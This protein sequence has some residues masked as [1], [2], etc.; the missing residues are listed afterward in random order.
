MNRP[1]RFWP[2][3]VLL[4]LPLIPLFRCLFLGQTIGAWDEIRTMAPWNRASNGRPWDVLQ[5]DSVLEFY[6]WRDQVFKAWGTYHI[7]LWNH[8]ELG[9]TPLLAN[10][11][12]GALYPPHIVV[13]LLHVPTGPAMALLAWL[14]LA[15]AGIGVYLLSRRFGGSKIGALL[16]GAAFSMSPFMIG[17]AALPSVT[18]TV[19]WIPWGILAIQMLPRRWGVVLLALSV[20]MMVSAGHLQFAA[21]GGIAWLIALVVRAFAESNARGQ[22]LVRA[23]VGLLLGAFL[24]APHIWPVLAYA[25]HS[26]RKTAPTME[27]YEAYRSGALPAWELLSIPDSTWLGIPTKPLTLGGA[28]VGGFWPA[29]VQRGGNFAESAIGIGPVALILLVL[30]LNRERLRNGLA[31]VLVAIT[32]LAL[33]IGLPLGMLLYFGIPGW[34]ATGSPGRAGVLFVLGACVLAGSCL[35][36][37]DLSNLRPWRAFCIFGVLAVVLPVL[38]L[39][40]IHPSLWVS[41]FDFHDLFPLSNAP[42]AI[43]GA[44]AACLFVSLL[45]PSGPLR[46]AGIVGLCLVVGFL[47]ASFLIRSSDSR[48]VS[49]PAV[50]DQ[51][52]IA[53]VNGPWSLLASAA[54]LLP[55]NTAA[56][57]SINEIGGYDSLIDVRTRDRLADIDGEDPAPAANGNM[58]FVKSHFDPAKLADAGVTEVWSLHPLPQMRTEPREA[59]GFLRYPLPGLGRAYTESGP[60]TIVHETASW[61]DVEASG[62]GTLVLKDNLREGWRLTV[63]DL[64]AR[65]ETIPWPHAA[66]TR[67]RHTVHFEYWPDGLT[68]GFTVFVFGVLGLVVIVLRPP[69][70]D[71]VEAGVPEGGS[72]GESRESEEGGQPSDEP[73]DRSP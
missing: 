12:T 34:A 58:M 1:H 70:R 54:A 59:S 64:P 56:L 35:K 31:P 4:A 16:G 53:V 15:W 40:V 26:H 22:F 38:A 10:S 7:P 61:I 51:T 37:E 50:P 57:S 73:G 48:D 67:G 25:Q 29:L 17:W 2:A 47:P 66:L 72:A 19:A 33:A 21:Y 30:G 44:A 32:G 24:A 27:G 9:G 41:G 71:G 52:R 28:T 49:V 42:L 68:Q 65:L 45:R 69:R 39:L 55:P 46:A 60:A 63:D 3:L 36:A 5:A 11:Q 20:A 43:G 18:E 14:H 62:P 13:G 6:G 23:G 8:S